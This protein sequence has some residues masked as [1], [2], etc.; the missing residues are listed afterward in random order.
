MRTKSNLSSKEREH[1]ARLQLASKPADLQIGMLIPDVKA[2][3]EAYLMAV[4]SM[5]TSMLPMRKMGEGIYTHIGNNIIRESS[6]GYRRMVR[7]LMVT[8]ISPMDYENEFT[9]ISQIH[10]EVSYMVDGEHIEQEMRSPFCTE[11]DAVFV[12]S[13]DQR[14][15]WILSECLKDSGK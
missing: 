13:Y 10:Y 14:L 6:M 9:H 5:N 3:L 12:F 8:S 7:N 2:V 4:Y 15:G 1:N 11:R